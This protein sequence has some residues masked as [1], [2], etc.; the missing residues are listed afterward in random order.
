MDTAV[1]TLPM[2]IE[3]IESEALDSWLEATSHRLSSTRGDFTEAVGLPV[4]AGAA[5]AW[6]IQLR[7]RRL[8]PS[9][10]PP[11]NRPLN[12]LRLKPDDIG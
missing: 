5:T 12:C 4:A 10:R 8:P 2:R 11:G 7:P 6:L 9:A 3:P 1:R